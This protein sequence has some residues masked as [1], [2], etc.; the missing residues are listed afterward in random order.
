MRHQNLIFRN[1]L[2]NIYFLQLW[3][4]VFVKIIFTIIFLFHKGLVIKLISI[5]GFFINYNIFLWD[6]LFI[7][8]LNFFLCVIFWFCTLIICFQFLCYFLLFF[9]FNFQN[10]F[11]AN[12]NS[13]VHP[14]MKCFVTSRLF[15]KFTDVEAMASSSYIQDSWKPINSIFLHERMHPWTFNNQ[16]E[17]VLSRSLFMLLHNLIPALLKN[18]APMA[19]LHVKVD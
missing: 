12:F 14:L 1:Q 2:L 10:L 18:L 8:Y 5:L 16:K 19:V 4:K 13:L 9:G 7:W 11:V 3:F 6:F 15:L 17:R